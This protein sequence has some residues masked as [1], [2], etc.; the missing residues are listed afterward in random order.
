MGE[1]V[2]DLLSFDAFPKQAGLQRGSSA[3]GS[4]LSRSRWDRDGARS[5]GSTADAANR[6]ADGWDKLPLRVGDTADRAA[7]GREREQGHMGHSNTY[8]ASGVI[9]EAFKQF[10]RSVGTQKGEQSI[11]GSR[12]KAET[13]MTSAAVASQL[14]RTKSEALALELL[15]QVS[16][17]RLHRGLYLRRHYDGS[18]IYVKYGDLQGFSK[19]MRATT[20]LTNMMLHWACNMFAGSSLTRR[21]RN[22]I[23]STLA[24]VV[25]WKLLLS[26][27]AFL[28]LPSTTMDSQV[29]RTG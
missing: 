20:C 23:W 5:S 2:C 22:K 10:G 4:A 29:L 18:P 25:L 9:K 7:R 17:G 3:W 11:D 12:H 26:T 27:L 6:L 14:F 1:Y 28:Q 19:I 21:K 16:Q 13:L 8:M 15:G 24:T